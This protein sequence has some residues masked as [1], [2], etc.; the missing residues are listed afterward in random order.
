MN[1]DNLKPAWR[2]FQSLNAMESLNK[3][4]ILLLIEKAA[5]MRLGNIHRYLTS[6][7]MFAVLI[8]F[9]QGG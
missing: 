5:E 8:I 1:L 3:N 9:C 2:H 7:I 6:T 4:E